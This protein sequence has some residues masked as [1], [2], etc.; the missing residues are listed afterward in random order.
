M[1]ECDYGKYATIFEATEEISKS[2]TYYL[3]EGKTTPIFSADEKE[4][5]IQ[6]LEK[7]FKKIREKDPCPQ[8]A[9]PKEDTDS[10]SKKRILLNLSMTRTVKTIYNLFFGKKV[11]QTQI[12]KI[13]YFRLEPGGEIPGYIKKKNLFLCDKIFS[14]KYIIH[15][16]KEEIST[17]VK[18]IKGKS[19]SQKSNPSIMNDD[20]QGRGSEMKDEEIKDSGKKKNPNDDKSFQNFGRDPNSDKKNP[21]LSPFGRDPNSD[22]KNPILSPFGRDPNSDKKNPILSPF[23]RDPNSDK[24]NPILSPFGRDP[25]SDKKNP[26]LSPFGRDPNS[27]KKNPILSPFGRDPNS[28]KKNP[29]LSPFGRDPNSDKKNPILSPFG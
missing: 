9:I 7:K 11:F 15:G 5:F 27:D 20:I 16:L 28:D 6:V 1:T 4:K 25:N 21:I 14:N 18:S 24:K 10:K 19:N 26:I 17:P 13:Y 29:I 12:K 23:G 3:L 22:K 8:I 2:S